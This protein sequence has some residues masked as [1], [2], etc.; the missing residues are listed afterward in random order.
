MVKIKQVTSLVVF[1]F[2]L[3][4]IKGCSKIIWRFKCGGWLFDAQPRLISHQAVCPTVTLT[5]Y[6]MISSF[7]TTISILNKIDLNLT[8]L[9]KYCSYKT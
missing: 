8:S 4:C 2:Y 9:P 7:C 6:G 3:Y 1:L 5:S